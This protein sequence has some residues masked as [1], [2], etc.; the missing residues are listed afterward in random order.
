YARSYSLKIHMDSSHLNIRPFACSY[1][2]CDQKFARKHDLQRHEN[3]HRNE[4]TFRCT[5]CA[6]NFRRKDHLEIH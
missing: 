3:I 2:R 4:R 6:K 1:E 5:K